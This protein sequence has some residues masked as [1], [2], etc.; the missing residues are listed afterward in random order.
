MLNHYKK[1]KDELGKRK[2]K[3]RGSFDIKKKWEQMNKAYLVSIVIQQ[4][5]QD[6]FYS[7][8][9]LMWMKTNLGYSLRYDG[10]YVKLHHC[11]K[12]E[13]IEPN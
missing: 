5:L 10:N 12:K 11:I 4:A 13:K 2:K 7:K 3:D 1:K 9:L 6:L 8:D